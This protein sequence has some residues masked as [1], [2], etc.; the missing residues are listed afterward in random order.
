MKTQANKILVV[1]DEVSAGRSIEKILAKKGFIVDVAL[2]ANE[3]LKKIEKE[4]F[5]LVLLDIM[6]PQVNG[7]ELLSI[8]KERWPNLKVMMVTGYPSIETAVDATR[9]GALDYISKPF[10]P[11]EIR[12]KVDE[13]LGEGLGGK[14]IP[15]RPVADE[16]PASFCPLGEQECEIYAKKGRSC[17]TKDGI[18]PKI[19]KAR[20]KAKGRPTFLAEEIGKSA[21]DIDLPFDY[22]EVARYTS[23]A[24]VNALD[25]SGVPMVNWEEL[26]EEVPAPVS[27]ILVIDDEVV[28]GNSIRKILTPKGYHVEHAETPDA[29]ME[30][31]S[32]RPV[33]MV[34]LDMKIPGVKGLD[35]LRTIK[36]ENPTTPVVMITG[37]ATVETAVESIKLGA[38]DYVPKPFTPNEIHQAVE[39]SFK[40]AA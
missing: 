40:L 22:N 33:D 27:E 8:I 13:A 15:F 9:L 11:A 31:L 6:M 20:L 36:E 32:E 16:V 1:D 17:K 12:E 2:D 28:V 38:T 23:P 7:I 3:G 29:A 18:C 21:I 35:L 34:L 30:I 25:S 5:E 26:P 10:T 19:K 37:Y 4:L 39:R 14:V 24:Y